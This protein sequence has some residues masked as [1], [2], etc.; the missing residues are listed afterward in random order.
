[1]DAVV[2][3]VGM[4]TDAAGWINVGAWVVASA[5]LAWA[6]QFNWK[7]LGGCPTVII[8]GFDSFSTLHLVTMLLLLT[9]VTL[10][11][12]ANREGLGLKG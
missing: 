10:G 7:N 8:L 1:M 11:L 2:C 12:F 6:S 4:T 9:G 3:Y 5:S